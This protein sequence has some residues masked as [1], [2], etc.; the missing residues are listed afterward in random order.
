MQSETKKVQFCTNS[1]KHSSNNLL[2]DRCNSYQE[3]KMQDLLK[4]Q[5]QSDVI[6]IFCKQMYQFNFLN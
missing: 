4:F 6:F 2:C 3:M 5:S 1:Q